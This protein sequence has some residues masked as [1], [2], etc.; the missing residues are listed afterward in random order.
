MQTITSQHLIFFLIQMTNFIPKLFSIRYK[1]YCCRNFTMCMSFHW[2]VRNIC[3][4]AEVW[5]PEV[6]NLSVLKHKLYAIIKSLSCKAIN[7]HTLHSK[8]TLC[9]KCWDASTVFPLH[10][11]LLFIVGFCAI[12]TC[13][14]CA[15]S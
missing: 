1:T 12:Y 6:L 14:L 7:N 2:G 8:M 9:H 5:N 3:C 4:N 13:L 11:F 15:Y 10:R